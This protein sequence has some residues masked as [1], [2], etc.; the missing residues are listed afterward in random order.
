[1]KKTLI[2]TTCI[3]LLSYVTLYAQNSCG[4]IITEEQVQLETS[5]SDSV[6]E[7]IFL[8]KTIYLSAHIV[9]QENGDNGI[10]EGAINGAIYNLNQLF[11]TIGLQFQLLKVNV[12]ENYNYNEL[13]YGIQ[14]I[15]LTNISSINKTINLYFV[16]NLYDID[17]AE[18]SAYTYMPAEKK[19]FVVFEKTS[20]N[21]TVLAE[22]IGHFF[23]LYHTHET[24][25]GKE[26]ANQSNCSNTGDLCCDTPA[27]PNLSG[28]VSEKCSCLGSQKDSLNISYSPSVKNFMSF[29]EQTC[30]C[31]FSKEQYIRMINAILK[32]KAHLL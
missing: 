32:L 20:F 26:L 28:L 14:D 30:K 31:Y 23:N 22:Q 2:V 7:I 12:I 10:D 17:K 19:D 11:E 18:V 15:Q 25:F 24:E 8:N 9:K 13:Y 6:S 21:Y 16:D 1:M 27:D 4:T 29:T 3:F 5:F